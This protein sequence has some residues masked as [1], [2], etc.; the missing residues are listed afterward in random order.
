M[1]NCVKCLKL[2]S[3]SFFFYFPDLKI[4][5]SLSAPPLTII[6]GSDQLQHR[7]C[8]EWPLRSNKGV[9]K[10]RMSHIFNTE[11][12][13]PETNTWSLPLHQSTHV[14]H[15]WNKIKFESVK[16]SVKIKNLDLNI[17]W[18]WFDEIFP[19]LLSPMRG[20]GSWVVGEFC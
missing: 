8:S 15:P 14:T 7:I 5:I 12:C 1:W 4:F 13:D 17:L 18:K 16:Q 3:S 6:L 9:L 10:A 2:F 11:S 19:V 20:R